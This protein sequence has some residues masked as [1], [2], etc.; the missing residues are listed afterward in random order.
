VPDPAGKEPRS[1][2]RDILLAKEGETIRR[3]TFAGPATGKVV[4]Q[5]EITPK[6]LAG[7]R[8]PRQ[9]VLER[10]DVS[11]GEK[12]QTLQL[13]PPYQLGDVSTSGRLALVALAQEGNRYD[14]LDVLG[15]A[16]KKHIAGWRPYTGEKE[17]QSTDTSRQRARRTIWS[18]PNDPRSVAWAA[19]LDDE[20]VL[21]VNT[22]GKLV[23]W[24]L[25]ECK[26]TYY[27]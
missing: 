27:F 15:L 11:T 24:R 19:L 21:T 5:K 1:K 9:V 16:P 25:P 20:H 4:V 6:A 26:A 18:L 22:A 23:C 2:D 10:Y 3:V 8:A 14:R 17:V 13:A 12:G 7:R